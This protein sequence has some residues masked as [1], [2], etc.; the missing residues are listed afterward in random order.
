MFKLQLA[1]HHYEEF[2]ASAIDP[3][4][5]K[6]NFQSLSGDDA[7]DCLLYNDGLNRRNDGRLSE[8]I[9]RVYRHLEHGGWYCPGSGGNANPSLWGT[10]KPDRPRKN[11][12]GKV[13]K[14]EHPP[15]EPTGAFFLEVS[16]KV[17]QKIALKNGLTVDTKDYDSFWDWVRKNNIP[18]VFTEGVKKA[19]ALLSLGFVAIALPGIN[20]GYRRQGRKRELIPCLLPYL[21]PGREIIFAFDSDEKP[22]T[23]LAVRSAIKHT[24]HLMA[25][26]GCRVSVAVWPYDLGKGIDDVIVGHGGDTALE[27]IE[28]RKSLDAYLSNKEEAW[29]R[30][31]RYK[32]FTPDIKV[33]QEYLTIDNLEE[34]TIYFVRS[35]LG[36][37]KTQGLI[38]WV[39]TN[40]EELKLRGLKLCGYRNL[41]LDQ[42]SNRLD[43][44]L[45]LSNSLENP[46]NLTGE[47]S[48]LDDNT[49]WVRFCVDSFHLFE[50][51][52]FNNAIVILDEVMS[53][54]KH[55]FEAKT[56]VSKD[57]MSALYLFCEM[58]KRASIVV[59]LDANLADWVR[60]FMNKVVNSA[61][62]APRH[63]KQMVSIENTYI[64]T[65]PSVTFYEGVVND[66][67]I[68]KNSKNGLIAKLRDEDRPAVVVSDNQ[69]FL[70]SLHNFFDG[71]KKILRIDKKTVSDH[72][73]FMV[74]PDGYIAT[75]KP[76]LLLISPVAESGISIDIKGYFSLVY[77]FF[78]GVFN[79][80]SITQLAARIREPIPRHLW[81]REW[82]V[83]D[84][85]GIKSP[86]EEM[87]A[88]SIQDALTYECSLFCDSLKNLSPIEIAKRATLEI[89]ERLE[90]DETAKILEETAV[91]LRAIGNFEAGNLRE[92]SQAQM[93]WMGYPTNDANPVPEPDLTDF[94]LATEEVKCVEAIEIETAIEPTPLEIE[95]P[96]EMK[97]ETWKEET[98][99]IKATYYNRVPGIAGSDL[100]N[101]DTIKYLRFTNRNFISHCERQY[102]LKFPIA[103]SGLG[104]RK[105]KQWLESEK[106]LGFDYRSEYGLLKAI[107]A[108]GITELLSPGVAY[109]NDSEAIQ[110]ICD[111]ARN[112]S[113]KAWIGSQGRS[114][115]IQF[116]GRI[117]AKI[118]FKWKVKQKNKERE[119]HLI[120]TLQTGDSP[121]KGLSA[122]NKARLCQM[123]AARLNSLTDFTTKNWESHLCNFWTGETPEPLRREDLSIAPVPS[124]DIYSQ[125]SGCGG[126]NTVSQ[127]IQGITEV[128][129]HPNSTEFSH[130]G[131]TPECRIYPQME[132]DEP[133]YEE[134]LE[135]IEEVDG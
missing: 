43:K 69:L 85:E 49:L 64:P 17:W 81:V 36:T 6:L 129:S 89:L 65:L 22:K 101:M 12:S 75:H 118:G 88:R 31:Q 21:L 30:W 132:D 8:G 68:F 23:K 3:S 94:K 105:M 77:G 125:R 50:P 66:K 59:C 121:E 55:I 78:F 7:Y 133:D 111:N 26:N 135:A 117:L 41:L 13:I 96:S 56:H 57:R 84:T 109:T 25:Q 63:R 113:V 71:R 54:I 116:V 97:T 73:E 34:N 102:Y 114:S 60:E 110:E 58:L 70:E 18:I 82:S 10:F 35:Q 32:S 16:E 61:T 79:C 98:T 126:Q 1:P 108:T 80:D 48:S 74:D 104:K 28:N 44:A 91:I 72:K 95:R 27:I 5:I 92:C 115:P 131:I 19:A 107:Q 62:S 45:S 76:E 52:H 9:L 42:T 14:Y 90:K 120:N 124:S 47:Y 11:K 46:R 4:L 20:S 112:R 87:I 128:F 67:G 2:I 38:G 51:D 86:F 119:Y 123:V 106:I 134:Y 100:W 53:V 93:V 122:A 83:V 127:A 37:G 29:K 99:K 130:L 24:G 40:Y 15:K 39:K 103:L 33:H